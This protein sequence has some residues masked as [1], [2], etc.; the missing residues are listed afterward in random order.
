[1]NRSQTIK[2]KQNYP[3]YM[4]A[5]IL[6]LTGPNIAEVRKKRRVSQTETALAA[7]L[8][9]AWLSKVEK[10]DKLPGLRH[11]TIQALADFLNVEWRVKP[12]K[13]TKAPKGA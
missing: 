9:Q 6:E 12:Q 10:G 5:E 8:T 11:E 2:P 7:G 3:S 13:T 1:M 4:R